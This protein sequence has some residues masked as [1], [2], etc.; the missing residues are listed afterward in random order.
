MGHILT[1]GA[2]EPLRIQHAGVVRRSYRHHRGTN[3]VRCR[4][5]GQ[6]VASSPCCSLNSARSLAH[7]ISRH[8]YLHALGS[9]GFASLHDHCLAQKGQPDTYQ[10]RRARCVLHKI[11]AT[12]DEDSQASHPSCTSSTR[13]ALLQ[14]SLQVCVLLYPL[15][16]VLGVGTA[17]AVPAT[18]DFFA[19]GQ[20]LQYMLGFILLCMGVTLSPR[21]FEQVVQRPQ[22]VAYGAQRMIHKHREEAWVSILMQLAPHR[23]SLAVQHHAA[24]GSSG[25]QVPW[26]ISCMAGV[27][28]RCVEL[29]R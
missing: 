3:A 19:Q 25:R 28:S 6:L 13:L 2:C 11:S 9:R 26:L 7:S 22:R 29:R 16:I 1:A 21:D 27:K 12:C 24:T 15:W 4:S 23:C 18:F 10:I 17:I 14:R 5:R 8:E 20:R